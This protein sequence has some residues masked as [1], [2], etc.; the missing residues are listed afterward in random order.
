LII[1]DILLPVVRG[2]ATDVSA[3]I[4]SDFSKSKNYYSETIAITK[5]VDEGIARSSI[6][7]DNGITVVNYSEEND[8]WK[9][10]LD[11]KIKKIASKSR[12]DFLIFCALTKERAAYSK[13][14][15]SIGAL[16]TIGGLNCQE[17][18]IDEFRGMCITPARM[19]LVNMA[20]TATKAIELFQ[21]KIVA[22]SGICAGVRG[23]SNFLDI[24]I[25]DIC[26]EYQ[27]GKYKDGGFKQEPY[28]VLLIMPLRQ[29]F[30]NYV[31]CLIF[32]K[33]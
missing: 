1:F 25:G 8:S 3:E 31:N 12:L 11:T 4:V 23:E 16:K 30:S 21:P 33:V 13:T 24:V 15:A 32:S 26:W 17:L 7:N 20:I 19:G 5:F 18:A 6:F 29:S 28:Q 22:M 14:F 2:N 9:R 10:G 27:T